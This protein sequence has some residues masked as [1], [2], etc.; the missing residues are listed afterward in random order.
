MNYISPHKLSTNQ[1][2]QNENYI[3]LY[4]NQN[5]YNVHNY[6]IVSK[7]DNIKNSKILTETQNQINKNNNNIHILHPES[8][9]Q[10]SIHII[11]NASEK[12]ETVQNNP[13]LKNENYQTNKEQ[14]QNYDDSN[15]Q[16]NIDNT[17]IPET[18]YYNLHTNEPVHNYM[19]YQT[20]EQNAAQP[21]HTHN[22]HNAHNAHNIYNSSYNNDDYNND[23]NNN[24]MINNAMIDNA[25]IGN[26]MINNAMLNDNVTHNQ[27]DEISN[28]F[29]NTHIIMS[30]QENRIDYKTN[31]SNN[32]SGDSI[33]QIKYGEY[34]NMMQYN[35]YESNSGK[36]ISP[37]Y[38][39]N[40]MN[41]FYSYN[42]NPSH[43]DPQ[44]I[45]YYYNNNNNSNTYSDEN[46]Q[47]MKINDVPTSVSADVPTSEPT[48]VPADVP[49][50]E[51]NRN[52]ANQ[53][54]VDLINMGKSFIS[55]FFSNI[56]EKIKIVDT[57]KE[58]TEK[59]DE[60]IFY[61]DYKKKRWR[62]KGVTSDEE[63][64]REETKLKNKMEMS[65]ITP[66]LVSN[67]YNNTNP[68]KPLDM[69]DVRSRYVDYFN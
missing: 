62:E 28:I 16:N 43:V 37:N 39:V 59:E 34:N 8:N 11:E 49:N 9:L 53:T 19:E 40:K 46:C 64:E 36:Y 21:M 7:N 35:Y 65:K 30:T 52:D 38:N 12:L 14:I 20:V 18:G 61:Y 68:K 57:G 51:P 48:S 6:K 26:A 54:N 10:N 2:L 69:K 29:P 41:D 56:K 50:S 31:Y 23:Y 32:I 67:A 5:N 60:N 3:N 45:N 17:L 13:F 1:N 25:M 44:N 33:P 58:E 47:K 66:P 55:G 42:N 63:K 27:P 24:G 15:Y 22:T 4:S